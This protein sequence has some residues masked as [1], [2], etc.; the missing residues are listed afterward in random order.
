MKFPS[1][2]IYIWYVLKLGN[3]FKFLTANK[4]F[5]RTLCKIK[6]CSREILP[7][8]SQK[9]F[10]IRFFYFEGAHHTPKVGCCQAQPQLNSTSTQAEF[11]F[12]LRQIQPPTHPPSQ[13]PTHPPVQNSSEKKL[14]PSSASTQLN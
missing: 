1:L 11:S 3:I 6:I 9:Y 10:K 13:P 14:K 2:L 5:S 7:H 8:R 4:I 12:I